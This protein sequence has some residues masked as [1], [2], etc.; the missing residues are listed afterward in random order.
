MIDRLCEYDA[1][2]DLLKGRIVLVTGAAAGIG[3]A[4]VLSY[5]KHAATVIMLD[6]QRRKLEILYDEICEHG[7]PE[8]VI[9]VQ[10]LAQATEET[11]QQIALGI[12]HDF[13]RLDGLLHN[14]AVIN[15][16]TPLRSHGWKDWQTSIK[17]NLEIPFLL[18]RELF[19]LLQAADFASVLFTSA[20]VG[21]RGRAYWGAYAVA[22]FGIEGLTQVWSAETE[23]NT[24][25][26]FNTLDPGPVRTKLRGKLYPGEDPANHPAPEDIVPAYLYLMGKDSRHVNGMALSVQPGLFDT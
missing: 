1:A 22:Y 4:V 8:P 7:W 14:A 19:P 24:S 25:I 26:R 12:A 21:R 18:T 2:P 3:R 6:R 15:A 11:C 20:D 17:V 16:L 5:A 13:G 9:V 10:D 23:V